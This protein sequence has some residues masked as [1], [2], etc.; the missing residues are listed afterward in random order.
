[1]LGPAPQTEDEENGITLEEGSPMLAEATSKLNET[2]F[3]E[4]L[5]QT[6]DVLNVEIPLIGHEIAL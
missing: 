5:A 2:T 4:P 1:V 6:P 3:N